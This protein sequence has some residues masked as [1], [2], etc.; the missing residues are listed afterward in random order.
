MSH[1]LFLQRHTLELVVQAVSLLCCNE[2]P[3]GSFIV[4][5]NLCFILSPELLK[6]FP[7]V[8]LIPGNWLLPPRSTTF[9][10][11]GSIPLIIAFIRAFQKQQF[12]LPKSLLS[13]TPSL[14]SS[15]YVTHDVH[16]FN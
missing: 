9:H 16:L 4:F 5:I 8:F 1:D 3:V 14:D 7:F 11:S 6:S 15:P 13:L 12:Q 10:A 2:Y